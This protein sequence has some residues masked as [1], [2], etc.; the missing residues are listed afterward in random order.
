MPV[1]GVEVALA[2]IGV[3]REG[4]GGFVRG[5]GGDTQK[6]CRGEDNLR[7]EGPEGLEEGGSLVRLPGDDGFTPGAG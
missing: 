3:Q 7:E 6:G 4:N 5:E 2:Q 1:H